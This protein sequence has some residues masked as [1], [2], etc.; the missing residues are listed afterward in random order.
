MEIDP[1]YKSKHFELSADVKVPSVLL[2][3]ERYNPKWQVE[4]DG[5]P[6]KLLRCDFIMR[7]IYLEPGKHHIVC[8]YVS[9]LTTLYVSVA[10]DLVAL[11]LCGYLAF[12]KDDP[13]PGSSEASESPPSTKSDGIK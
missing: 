13:E 11:L 10:A 12:T 7:G 5:K 1:N 8:Q 9:K 3:T 6:A 4:V 2:M